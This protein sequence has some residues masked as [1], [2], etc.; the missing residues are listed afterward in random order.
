M[1]VARRSAKHGAGGSERWCC[2]FYCATAPT[3]SEPAKQVCEMEA[4]G[5]VLRKNVGALVKDK[6]A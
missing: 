6:H 3:A 1:S 5:V 2:F 4:L